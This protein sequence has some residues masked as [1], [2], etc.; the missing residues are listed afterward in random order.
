MTG[1]RKPGL[2][3]ALKLEDL[4]GVQAQLWVDAA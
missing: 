2:E 1:R 4:L 3:L